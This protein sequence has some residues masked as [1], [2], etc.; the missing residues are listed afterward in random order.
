M[1]L[2]TLKVRSRT[3][4]SFLTNSKLVS[5]MEVTE[6]DVTEN[7][8][9]DPFESIY[10]KIFS[11]IAWI[12]LLPSCGVAVC[13]IWYEV[14]G[15]AGPYR[16]S[17]NQLVSRLYFLVCLYFLVITSFDLIRVWYG[18]ISEIPCITSQILR[19]TIFMMAAMLWLVVAIL[20]LWI[21]CIRKALPYM[22]DDFITCFI[23]RLS[24]MLSFLY[25]LVGV[26]VPQ[27]P[28]LAHVSWH[29]SRRVFGPKFLPWVLFSVDL[30][31]KIW[32]FR[33]WEEKNFPNPCY[34][35]GTCFDCQPR[36]YCFSILSKK[37]DGKIRRQTNK[38]LRVIFKVP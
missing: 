16:T 13:F 6:E 38:K 21:V 35:H 20:K 30:S 11:T 10:S 15:S 9:M 36:L 19:H 12:G 28:A 37:K 14:N 34:Y 29:I 31:W 26:I 17:I 18:P 24:F 8:F 1:Q 25:S 2:L 3:L 4:L 27:K 7:Y 23:T 22:D 32:T 33:T 5:K